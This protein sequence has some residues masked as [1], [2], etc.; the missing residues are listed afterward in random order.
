MTRLAVLVALAAMIVPAG[1]AAADSLFAMSGGASGTLIS[2]E[3]AR[4]KKGD[5]VTVLVRESIDASTEA[6]TNTRKE[7]DAES[8]AEQGE[9]AFFVTAPKGR[10]A[11]LEAAE[12]P[13]WN[14]EAE[15]EHRARGATE[16]TNKLV[17]TVACR[18]TEVYPNDNV[19]IEGSKDVTVNREDSKIRV[20]GVVRAEDID[21]TNTVESYRL[22]DAVIE[23]KG[24]GPLWNNQRRGLFT[25][26][27]D[28]I[29]PY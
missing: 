24:C 12:L 20:S 4:L 23:L 1:W 19:R 11:F 17:T 28:W 10:S 22:A 2:R 26:L 5:I 13:N 14:V 18:V 27:L 29:A 21:S 3:R 9:N 6:N 16:R 7:A 8:E 25:R 15:K